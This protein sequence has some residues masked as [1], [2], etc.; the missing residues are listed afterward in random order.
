MTSNHS[1][2]WWQRATVYQIYPRSFQDSDGDGVGDLRGII[3]RLDYLNDGTPDSLGVD[4]IWLCPFYRSPMADF[5]YDVADYRDVDPLFGTLDDFDELLAGAHERGIKVIIDWVPNHS[6]NR[7]PWFE[8]SRSSKDNPKRHWYVWAD[9]SREGGPPNN[10][11]SAF[12]REGAAWTLDETTGQYY[13]HSFLAAQPDLNWDN[14][15]V[16][17]AMHDVL[18]FW[19]DR[20]VDGF[21]MDVVHKIGKDPFL[22]DNPR[23][24]DEAFIKSTAMRHDED[25]PSVHERLRRIRQVLEE[26]DGERAGVGEVYLL[27][28]RRLVEYVN[29]TR[30]L[31]LAHNFAFLHQPWEAGAFHQAIRE[32]QSLSTPGAWAAWFLENH[33]HDRIP[34]RYGGGDPEGIGRRRARVAALLL[35]TLRG[36]PFIYQGG[37]LGLPNSPIPA[38]RVVDVDGRD[39]VRTPMPWEPPGANGVTA[40][41]GFSAGKPWLPLDPRAEELAVSRQREDPDSVLNL[42]RRLIRLRREEPVLQTGDILLL[43][44]TEGLL[45]YL[46]SLEHRRFLVLLN[47]TSEEVEFRGHEVHV[48]GRGHR[49]MPLGLPTTLWTGTG[50]VRAATDL[51]LDDEVVDTR[52]L[53]IGPDAGLIIELDRS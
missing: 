5:G 14:P 25:W 1:L 41:A 33:D 17:A 20:G 51:A 35:M 34:T 24:R 22:R 49:S 3:R 27:N 2:H 16:E 32:F 6:S 42:Y 9:P 10:W 53:R 19:L 45:M 7:H 4:A 31:H 15:E 52:L 29:S 44:G 50:T 30:Q 39:P 43:E 46:R 26:Y 8:E 21:R 48:T 11:R 12:T 23:D 18:R 38:D 13:L 47:F 28:Q 37:E 40:A 36:T